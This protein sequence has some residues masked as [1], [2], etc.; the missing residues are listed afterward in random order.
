[1]IGCVHDYYFFAWDDQEASSLGV[2]GQRACSLSDLP[3]S[4][5]L[6]L[7]LEGGTKR[8]EKTVADPTRPKK[9]K[10]DKK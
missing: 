9:N 4:L 8:L 10:I 3:L 2:I 1:M 6:S 5:Y 7:S